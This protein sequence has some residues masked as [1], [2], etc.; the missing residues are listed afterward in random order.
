MN[1]GTAVVLIVLIAIVGAIIA[2]WVKAHR[3]GRHIGCDDCGGDCSSGSCGCADMMVEHMDD[4]IDE[5]KH[6]A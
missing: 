4:S 3:E 5:K 6:A 1:V 2:S